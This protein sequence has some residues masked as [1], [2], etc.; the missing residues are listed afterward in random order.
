MAKR[1][2]PRTTA[3][4]EARLDESLRRAR[5]RIAWREARDREEEERRARAAESLIYR[6][7]MRIARF[8]AP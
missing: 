8:V 2:M 5:E 1:R 4:E 7:R 6:L 3:E